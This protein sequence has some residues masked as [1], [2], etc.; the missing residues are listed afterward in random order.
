MYEQ[1]NMTW[2]RRT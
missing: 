1:F 2:C